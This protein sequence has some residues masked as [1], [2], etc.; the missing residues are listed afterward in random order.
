MILTLLSV[1]TG[2]CPLHK[3]TNSTHKSPINKAIN[4]GMISDFNKMWISQ[5]WLTS[6]KVHHY[7]CELCRAT[8]LR[9]GFGNESIIYS[10]CYCHIRFGADSSWRLWSESQLRNLIVLSEWRSLAT[11]APLNGNDLPYQY[12]LPA[13]CLP[14]WICI[15]T[16]ASRDQ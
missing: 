2:R 8:C 1:D 3:N 6:G 9:C 13:R 10:G 14:R 12:H 4:L 5:P 16:D 15:M 7:R 11:N